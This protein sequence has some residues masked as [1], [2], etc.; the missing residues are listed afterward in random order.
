MEALLPFVFKI[1]PNLS[2]FDRWRDDLGGNRVDNGRVF[3][4]R[5]VLRIS[6]L[7][8]YNEPCFR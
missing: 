8:L 1:P 2:H 4:S 7:G 5:L 3:V 6:R